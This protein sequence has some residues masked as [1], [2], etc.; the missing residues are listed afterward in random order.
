MIIDNVKCVVQGDGC[1]EEREKF[2]KLC[3]AD[4]RIKRV[5]RVTMHDYGHAAKAGTAEVV[6]R[7]GMT[8]EDVQLAERQIYSAMK[9]EC[10]LEIWLVPVTDGDIA[11]SDVEDGED[12]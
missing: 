2:M 9:E 11:D 7:D 3:R 5:G 10:G 8:L 12:E 6:F 4:E 1:K